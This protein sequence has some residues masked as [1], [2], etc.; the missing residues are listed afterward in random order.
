MYAMNMMQHADEVTLS[1]RRRGGGPCFGDN[2]SLLGLIVS[3]PRR[4]GSCCQC[5][6]RH[7]YYRPC[8]QC[9]HGP[10][11]DRPMLPSRHSS[12]IPVARP[13]PAWIS[14]IPNFPQCAHA[15]HRTSAAAGACSGGASPL[16]S[17]ASRPRTWDRKIVPSTC[18][19]QTLDSR[20]APCTQLRCKVCQAY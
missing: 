19:L 13:G 6:Q 9:L 8:R 18:S 3:G 14:V 12:R 4:D 17:E 16:P 1:T 10:C 11:A 5:L 15:K 7:L 2:G 20:A